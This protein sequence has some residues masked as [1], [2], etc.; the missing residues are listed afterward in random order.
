M[1]PIDFNHTSKNLS[2]EEVKK[3]KRWYCYHHK[4]ETC[5]KWKYKILKKVKLLFN[6]SSISLTSI[7]V[8]TSSMCFNPVVIGC[9]S[10]SGLV[11]QG[12]LTKSNFDKK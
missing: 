12:Y 6:M 11:I 10:G 2:E 3:L 4:L 8:I 5:Y 7:G 9:V 1:N